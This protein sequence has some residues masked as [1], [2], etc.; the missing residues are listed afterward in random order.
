MLCPNLGPSQ[1]A[2]DLR[3]A[4]YS[5]GR[6][7]CATAPAASRLATEFARRQRSDSRVSIGGCLAAKPGASPGRCAR[8]PRASEPGAQTGVAASL[9]R[10]GEALDVADLRGDRERVDP[11]EAG[12]RDQQRDVA[13]VGAEV[14]ELRSSRAICNSRSSISPRLTSTLRRHGSGVSRRSSRS[15]PASPNRSLT[16]HGCPKAISVAWM[17]FFS[18]VRCRTRCRRKRASSRSRR[19]AG[20]GEGVRSCVCVRPRRLWSCQ[21]G[22]RSPKWIFRR[23]RAPV[24]LS[25]LRQ[26]PWARWMA[27]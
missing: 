11:S 10:R 18:V 22:S 12:R 26:A 17:R 13:V 5:P 6:F 20:S 16:G 21:S 8:W 3:C 7:A 14:L 25:G 19:I 2:A 27:R 24:Q 9:D 23:R 15:R 1:R 4:S